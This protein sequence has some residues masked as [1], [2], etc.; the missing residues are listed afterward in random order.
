[1]QVQSRS[2]EET[3]AK[4]VTRG[5]L[6]KPQDASP[7][8]PPETPSKTWSSPGWSTLIRKAALASS[9]YCRSIADSSCRNGRLIYM[10]IGAGSSNLLKMSC[11]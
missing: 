7:D 11:W 2:R 5:Q 3:V 1:M 9:R 4:T 6:V 10:E 8:P